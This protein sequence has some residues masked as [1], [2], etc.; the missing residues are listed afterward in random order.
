MP[1]PQFI[2]V[3]LKANRAHITISSVTFNEDLHT[4]L[5]SP[6]VDRNGKPRKPQ[7]PVPSSPASPGVAEGEAAPTAT[8]PPEANKEAKP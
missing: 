1:D 8:T 4:L 3:S 2:R 7:Y 5:K 6:A